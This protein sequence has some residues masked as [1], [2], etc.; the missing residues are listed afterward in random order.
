M[1]ATEPSR[2]H[3]LSTFSSRSATASKSESDKHQA[4]DAVKRDALPPKVRL[5]LPRPRTCAPA[6]C[7]CGGE[8]GQCVTPRGFARRNPPRRWPSSTLGAHPC[9]ASAASD[10][11]L[12]DAAGSATTTIVPARTDSPGLELY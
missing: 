8:C 1:L 3:I 10:L 2:E 11:D 12:S 9:R 7:G 5:R 4:D 6:R